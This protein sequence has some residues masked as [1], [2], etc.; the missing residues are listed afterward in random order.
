MGSDPKMKIIQAL[1][2]NRF[3][4]RTVDGVVSEVKEPKAVVVETIKDLSRQGLVVRSSTPST[5][6]EAL[7]TTRKHYQQTTPITRRLIDAFKN[8]GG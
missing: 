7:F 3:K 2:N 5:T 4:W 8:R 1:E 6:G